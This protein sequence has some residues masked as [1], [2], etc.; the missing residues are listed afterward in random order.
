MNAGLSIAHCSAHPFAWHS[1]KLSVFDT[2]LPKNSEMRCCTSGMRT[3]PP[4]ISTLE[5]SSFASPQS[6]KASASS[7]SSFVS[8]GAAV[9][10]KRSRSI[11]PRTS[12]SSMK[13]S[14]AIGDCAFALST[15]HVERCTSGVSQSGCHV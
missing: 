12:M 3:D 15:C 6:A 10:R 9:S 8:S 1:S 5:I 4:T 14:I 11:M 13:H 7:A 2:S